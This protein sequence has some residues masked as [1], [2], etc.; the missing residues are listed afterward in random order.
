MIAEYRAERA[1]SEKKIATAAPLAVL[2][3]VRRPG[4]RMP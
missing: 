3:N 4:R 1:V 2:T